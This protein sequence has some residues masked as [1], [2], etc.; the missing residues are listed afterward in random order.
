MKN[1]YKK[2][3]IMFVMVL[4]IMGIGAINNGYVANASESEYTHKEDYSKNLIAE[5]KFDETSGNTCI[6]SVGNYNGTYNGTQSVVGVKN[7]ARVFNG[8]SDYISFGNQVIPSGKKTI[9]FKIKVEDVPDEESYV[10]ENSNQDSSFNGIR[11]IVSPNGN[12]G[13]A[14]DQGVLGKYRYIITSPNSICDSTWH[15][16]LF[17]WDGTTEVDSVK[18][19]VDN[20]TIPV[21]TT[22]ALSTE[23]KASSKTLS[24]GRSNNLYAYR[25]FKGELDELEIYNEVVDYKEEI[26]EEPDGSNKTGAI[27]I[28]NLVDGE[29]KVY[30]VT[31]SEAKKFIDWYDKHDKETYRFDKDVDQKISVNEYVIHDKITM[32]EVRKY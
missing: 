23:T 14:S 28:I 19:Y 15:T 9:S 29:T 18:L 20:L 2:I 26:P 1:T 4:G 12:I 24:I 30:D 31:T 21:V 32:F 10:I 16:V 8:T 17:T 27:L 25:Y 11:I 3:I 5:Y 22:T 6:D 13:V 7:N